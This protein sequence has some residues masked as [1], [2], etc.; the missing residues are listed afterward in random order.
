[1]HRFHYV[2]MV[3]PPAPPAR[4]PCLACIP[5]HLL[6]GRQ[7]GRLERLADLSPIEK[8][9]EHEGAGG[10]GRG[11]G[12]GT[13]RTQGSCVAMTLLPVLGAFLVPVVSLLERCECT[14]K[15]SPCRSLPAE[16]P[17]RHEPECTECS[18]A[19]RVT[20]VTPC[21]PHAVQ[22]LQAGVDVEV[23]KQQVVALAVAHQVHQPQL[24]HH[25]MGQ[26]EQVSSCSACRGGVAAEGGWLFR[27]TAC[28]CSAA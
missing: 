24:L 6:A 14:A 7:G 25:L 20:H 18:T 11:R 10:S 8:N 28:T 23:H 3:P 27:S 1:M 26:T 19:P 9:G 21:S 17:G 2:I 5:S 15:P 12:G 16:S 4:Q 13:R 22:D